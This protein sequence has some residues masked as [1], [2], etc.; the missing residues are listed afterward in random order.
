MNFCSAGVHPQYLRDVDFSPDGSYFVYV[1]TGFMPRFGGANR[2]I[3]DAVAR[4][5]TNTLNPNRPTWIN[6]SGGDT[7]HSVAA[8]GAAV[9]AQGHIRQMNDPAW[10]TPGPAVDREGIG[11]INPTTGVALSWNPGK[12]RG[13]GGKEMLA[14]PAG[15]WVGSDTPRF[16]GEFRSDLAFLPLN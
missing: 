6:Y 9:Y 5:E 11:A 13:V 12:T 14:T 10:P 4:F 16:A 1:S 2:D 8:T 15:L 7:Y 3:C